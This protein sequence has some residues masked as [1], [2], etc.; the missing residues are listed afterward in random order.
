MSDQEDE[1]GRDREPVEGS[2]RGLGLLAVVGST[3]AAAFG[4]QSR[5]ARER[6]FT[7]GNVIIFVIAGV[8]FTGLFV[9]AVST[10]VGL[11]LRA[12]GP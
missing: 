11:V 9:L 3:L 10:V 8:V 6:D 1:E 12:A 4:V 7:R 5:R 2:G